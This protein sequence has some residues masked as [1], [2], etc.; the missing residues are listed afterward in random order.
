MKLTW[1]CLLAG[2]A[3]GAVG[4]HS[5]T[6]WDYI[7]SHHCVFDTRQEQGYVIANGERELNPLEH[8]STSYYCE[9]DHQWVEV[10]DSELPRGVSPQLSAVPG[11]AKGGKP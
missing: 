11:L 2:M 7:Q 5:R 4:C 10:Y 3:A 6:N 1:L 9:P 8:P